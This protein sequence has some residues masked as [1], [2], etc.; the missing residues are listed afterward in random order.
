MEENSE[1][2]NTET[3]EQ[4]LYRQHRE[5]VAKYQETHKEQITKSRQAR[6]QRIKDDPE[7]YKQLQEKRKQYYQNV[8][9]PRLD[10]KTTSSKTEN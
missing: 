8:V 5:S 9:K 7:R 6:E 2:L 4:R 1:V 3:K 10:N